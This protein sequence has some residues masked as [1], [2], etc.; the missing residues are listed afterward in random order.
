MKSFIFSWIGSCDEEKG[1]KRKAEH[2]RACP[3]PLTPPIQ[4]CPKAT[5][6][7]AMALKKELPNNEQF[8][9]LSIL[10]KASLPSIALSTVV[11]PKPEQEPNLRGSLCRGA[12]LDKTVILD[13]QKRS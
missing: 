13:L 12:R 5:N 10:D 9:F 6:F 1:L 2:R 8:M 11:N 7:H 3:A 4:I